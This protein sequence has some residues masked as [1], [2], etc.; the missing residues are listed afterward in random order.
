MID[1]DR[2]IARNQGAWARLEALTTAAGRGPRRLAP[3]EL[4]ELVQLYQRA[5]AHLAHARG[6][7]RDPALLSRLT[8]A[9]GGANAVLYGSRSR[10]GAAA[11]RFFAET[12]PAAVWGARRYV[13]VSAAALLVPAVAVGVWLVLSDQ[14][15]DVALPPEARE[16]YLAS[17]FE[18]YYSSAP[19]GQ[20]STEVLINNIRVS[21]LAFA[22]GVALCIPTLLVLVI[23]G[24]NIGVAGGA[25]VDAGQGGQFFGLILPHGLLELTAVIVAGA[26]GLRLGWALIAPGDRTRATA[27]AEEG[28]RSVAIVLGLILV[29]VVAGLIEGYVTPSSLPTAVRVGIGVAVQVLFL[30]WVIGYGRRAEALGLTGALGETPRAEPAERAMS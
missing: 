29:F 2:F 26:A 28:R 7:Y 10:T 15:L 1:I 23:N 11:A 21:I 5:S 18:D 20:F 9:V 17:E 27:V 14:A 4:E 6:T 16:A 25:F 22:V 8:A 24:A 30:T 3:G 12:F 13:A 19:A